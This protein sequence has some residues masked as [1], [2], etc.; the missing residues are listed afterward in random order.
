MKWNKKKHKYKKGEVWIV[1]N[2]SDT[3]V[4]GSK[5]DNK[6]WIKMCY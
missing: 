4:L 5:I 1:T 2:T 3:Q 6:R